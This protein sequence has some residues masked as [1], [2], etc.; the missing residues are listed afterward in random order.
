MKEDGDEYVDDEDDVEAQ[1]QAMMGFGGFGTTKEK[2]VAGNDAGTAR[3]EKKAEYRQYMYVYHFY[4]RRETL[5]MHLQ[6]SCWW[7]QQSSFPS[8]FVARRA[9]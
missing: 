3:I 4:N 1:M 2:K 8:K 7:F 6:E 5:L 9:A